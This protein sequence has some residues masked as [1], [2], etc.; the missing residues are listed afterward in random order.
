M[1][2]RRFSDP[3]LTRAKF[4]STCSN[5]G[6]VVNKGDSIVYDKFRKL[7]YCIQ[8]TGSDCGSEILR[9]VQAERSMDQYGTD[10][11]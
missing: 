3:Y 5:C 6:K 9:T 7:V 11:Y 4:R 2:K 10:I 1:S 8:E